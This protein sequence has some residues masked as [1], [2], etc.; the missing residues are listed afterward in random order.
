MNPPF[1]SQVY[2]Y[3]WNTGQKMEFMYEIEIRTKISRSTFKITESLYTK[4]KSDCAE[5][6]MPQ[7]VFVEITNK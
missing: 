6:E 5:K 1:T 3:K 7:G 4:L 2:L